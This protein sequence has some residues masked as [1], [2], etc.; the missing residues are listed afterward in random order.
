MLGILAQLAALTF[1]GVLGNISFICRAYGRYSAKLLTFPQVYG[2]VRVGVCRL[3]CKSGG[4]NCKKN[5]VWLTN[6][7]QNLRVIA[8]LFASV[9]ADVALRR[10]SSHNR[11][12]WLQSQR[13]WGQFVGQLFMCSCRKICDNYC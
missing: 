6:Y 2:D 5:D 13:I 11:H 12:A 4:V 3:S 10:C 1:C 9:G 7:V 8:Q